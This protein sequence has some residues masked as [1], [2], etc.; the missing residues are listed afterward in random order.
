MNPNIQKK[1]DAVLDRVKDPQ[2][3]MTAAQ[4]GLVEKVRVSEKMNILTIFYAPMGK[5]KACCSVLNMAVLS[6]IETAMEKEFK[7]EFP[8]FIIK[9][10]NAG[11]KEPLQAG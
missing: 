9:S 8:G 11:G 4:M 5:S 2:S 6:E 7:K 3:G 1:I 10:A